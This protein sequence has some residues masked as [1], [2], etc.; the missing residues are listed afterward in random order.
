MPKVCLDPAY[1]VN[2]AFNIV[3]SS[4]AGAKA[5]AKSEGV[6]CPANRRRD[7]A[8]QKEWRAGGEPRVAQCNDGAEQRA[9]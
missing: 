7:G 4:I 3:S 6:K 9:K 1:A 5:S 8:H 2:R